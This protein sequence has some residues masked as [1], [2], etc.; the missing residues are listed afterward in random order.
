[1]HIPELFTTEDLCARLHVTRR[2]VEKRVAL[3]DLRPIK[4]GRLN[5]FTEAEIVRYLQEHNGSVAED[6]SWIETA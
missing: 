3:G 6:D 1:M 4:L 5:R 2:W